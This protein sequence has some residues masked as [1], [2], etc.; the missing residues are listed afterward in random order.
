MADRNNTKITIKKL[1]LP[2]ILVVAAFVLSG[3]STWSSFRQTFITE[4]RS[5]TEQTI[6]IG[7]IEP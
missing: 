4:P 7:V 3:C 1:L 6:T 5:E 2:A